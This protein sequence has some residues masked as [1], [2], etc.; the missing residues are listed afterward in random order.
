MDLNTTSICHI[1]T[2][3]LF[4]QVHCNFSYLLYSHKQNNILVILLQPKHV[5]RA[6]IFHWILIRLLKETYVLIKTN[7]FHLFYEKIKTTKQTTN[8]DFPLCVGRKCSPQLCICDVCFSIS[9]KSA[10]HSTC[11]ALDDLTVL[12]SFSFVVWKSPGTAEEAFI[13]PH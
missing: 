11:V 9:K 8:W 10:C 3:S 1:P 5:H 4:H 13:S 2:V 7:F 12:F 6:I